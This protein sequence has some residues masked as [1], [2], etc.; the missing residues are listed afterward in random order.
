MRQNVNELT[1]AFRTQGYITEKQLDDAGIM[2]VADGRSK[3][4][5]E[6]V[7]HQQRAMI[8]NSEENIKR[9]ANYVILKAKE[10]VKAK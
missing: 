2:S 8:L 9:L 1:L 7:P 3:P 5:D 10:E 6:R 4:K